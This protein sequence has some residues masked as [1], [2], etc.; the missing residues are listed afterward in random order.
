MDAAIRV[1]HGHGFIPRL[2]SRG[3]VA[4]VKKDTVADVR[5]QKFCV[6]FKSTYEA[7]NI[8]WTVRSWIRLRSV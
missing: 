3:P 4:S 5:L 6:T 1:R 7:D 8:V 2:A